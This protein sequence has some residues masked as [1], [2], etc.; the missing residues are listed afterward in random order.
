M[1]PHGMVLTCCLLAHN[2]MEVLAGL[3]GGCG[4]V[5]AFKFLKGD[6][7]VLV[8]VS[9]GEVHLSDV[10]GLVWRGT[11]LQKT[12]TMRFCCAKACAGLG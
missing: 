10:Q 12:Y 3:S 4:L 6:L 5:E 7:T 11:V 2:D 1:Q 9:L 8:G